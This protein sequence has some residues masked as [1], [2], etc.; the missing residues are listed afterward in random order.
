MELQ[1][2]DPRGGGWMGAGWEAEAGWSAESVTNPPCEPD[3][4]VL[5]QWVP[6]QRGHQGRVRAP[7]GFPSTLPHPTLRVLPALLLGSFS[8]LPPWAQQVFE[9]RLG[10]TAS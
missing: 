8:S 3:A 9:A 7:C 4:W 1:P 5:K 10:H 2:G 6:T